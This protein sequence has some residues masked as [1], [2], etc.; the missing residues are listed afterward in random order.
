MGFSK[1]PLGSAAPEAHLAGHPWCIPIFCSSMLPKS[2]V[3]NLQLYVT[4]SHI[5][6][7]YVYYKITQ[8]F[9]QLGVQLSDFYMGRP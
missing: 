7:L 2:G 1:F 5:C 4:H 6:G 9:K 8:L 3:S